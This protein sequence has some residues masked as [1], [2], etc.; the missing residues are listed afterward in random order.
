MGV[1][2]SVLGACTFLNSFQN[3]V[4]HAFEVLGI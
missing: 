2:G 3:E 1:E 4:L